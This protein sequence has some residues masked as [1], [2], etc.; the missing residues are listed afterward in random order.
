M[1]LA[2][3]PGSCFLR[4]AAAILVLSLGGLACRGSVSGSSQMGGG[5]QNN[6]TTGGAG[7]GGANTGGTTGANT[8]GT[9]GA[10]TAGSSGPTADGWPVFAP[11]RAYQLRRLTTQQY[12]ASVQTLLGLPATGMP[13]IEAIPAVAGFSAIGASSVAVS[14]AGVGQFENAA[15]FLAQAA[16]A[17]TGP[18][19][20]LVPCTPTGPADAA[21]LTSF[22]TAFGKR[23]FRRPLAAGEV[24]SYAALASGVAMATGDVWQGLEATVSAFLQSPHFLYLTEVGVPDPG[25]PARFRYTDYE[26]ASRLAYFLTNNT[27]DD[28]LLAAA[29]SGTLVTVAG[30][31]AQATRLLALPSARDAVRAFF[32]SLLSLDNLDTMTR[33]TALFPKFTAT[34]GPAMKQET[35]LVVDDLVFGRD[36]DYRHL[37]D[38]PDTFVNAELASLYG[39][40]PPAGT[41]FARATL[42]ASAGRVGLLGQAGVLAARD[43]SDGTSPTRRG[44]FVLTRLLCQDL[45]LAP[46]ANLQIPPPPSGVLTARQKL[47]Q[48]TTNAVCASCHRQTDPV[49]LSLEKFDAMGVYRETDHGLA[50][51]DTGQI[52]GMS[53]QGAAG[54]GA[55][56]RDHPALNPCLI[57]ALYGVGVGHLATDFDR[58]TFTSMVGAFQTSGARIR[59]LMAAMAASDGFRFLPAAT[60]QN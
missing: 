25:N 1:W 22:V 3:Q 31:Q 21:C 8:G 44:L 41:G 12:T 27:P 2:P 46:P 60:G 15:R 51:D 40:A 30:V 4:R 13:P 52:G 23:A 37:F 10:N 16:F 57:Q 17:P 6:P 9:T 47:D 55:I 53:Y 49:G 28:A 19:Q 48:H 54:L 29:A 5:G 24:T 20:K 7:N 26:M 11:P 34:L 35:L 50:I 58:P 45:P 59:G 43:H 39:L 36:G 56:L 18:R 14:G 38:Q 42:P 33:P 32:T